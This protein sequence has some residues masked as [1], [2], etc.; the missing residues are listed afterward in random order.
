M[1]QKIVGYIPRLLFKI[2]LYLKEKFD[3]KPPLAEE[4]KVV[5]DIAIKVIS[6]PDTILMFTPTTELRYIKNDR[7]QIYITI[8]GRVINLINHVY[9]Y[10][11]FLENNEMFI[12]VRSSF[13][14]EV[15]KR[16]KSL[17]EEIKSNIRYSLNTILKELD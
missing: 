16:R 3:P 2:Y 14:E 12:K 6:Y 7:K 8:D 10:N 5:C 13:D 17:D 15:E 11:V 1:E 9:S 4:E